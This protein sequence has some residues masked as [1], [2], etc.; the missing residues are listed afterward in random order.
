M[1]LKCGLT[2]VASLQLSNSVSVR[3]IPMVNPTLGVH[4]TM[5]AGTRQQ[6]ILINRYFVGLVAKLLQKLSAEKRSDGSTLLD[7]TLVVWGTEMAIGNP[8]KDPVPIFVAGGHPTEGY[9]KQG[10]LLLLTQPHRTTR[11]LLSVATAMGVVA[12]DHLG[13]LTDETSRGPLPGA[14]RVA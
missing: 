10:A 12:A 9:F 6:K 5:H 8:L 2:R 13:D 14:S 7:E 4:P 3:R 1:S 11:L